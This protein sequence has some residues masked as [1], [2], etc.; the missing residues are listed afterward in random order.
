MT[1]TQ[2]GYAGPLF[3]EKATPLL[4]VDLD[5]TVRHGKTELGRFVH[6]PD[7]VVVFP[8]AVEQI[9]RW[10]ARGGRVVAVS[11]QG[12]IALGHTDMTQ[13]SAAMMRTQVLCE[14]MFDKI[15]WCPHYDSPA[16]ENPE[17]RYCWCR[18]PS[19][20]LLIEG[21][22]E[23]AAK[24]GEYYPP[25]LGLFVGDRP[26]DQECARL[27]GFPFQWAADWRAEAG[28]RGEP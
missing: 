22:L 1:T 8:E 3:P 16:V 4:A 18:K 19:P 21:A 27:A 10:K 17:M 23:L 12:G 5:G 13:C 25:H 26:E 15:S 20:G 28:K 11:N 6:G 24:Y 7:D 9:R 14:D 2:Q